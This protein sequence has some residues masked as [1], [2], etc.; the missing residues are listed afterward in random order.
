MDYTGILLDLTALFATVWALD[1]FYFRRRRQQRAS[2]SGT[3]GRDPW[4]VAW[5][6]SLLPVLLLVGVFRSA[7]A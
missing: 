2:E 6:R 3:V 7:V 1:R 4:A 5:A